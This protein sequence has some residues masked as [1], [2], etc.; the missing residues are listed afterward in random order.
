MSRRRCAPTRRPARTRVAP[1]CCSRLTSSTWLCG[2]SLAT[3]GGGAAASVGAA[4]CGLGCGERQQADAERGH[5]AHGRARLRPCRRIRRLRPPALMRVEVGRR[6]D[7]LPGKAQADH[8][9][10]RR[11]QEAQLLGLQPLA[12]DRAELRADH[13]A[14][15]SAARPATTSTVWFCEACSTVVAAVRNTIWNSEVPDHDVGRHAQEIDHRRHHDEAAAHAHDGGQQADE[16]A[17][18]EAAGWR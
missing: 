7:Q 11:Q 10:Q 2:A 9:H 3:G 17:D 5:Q 13:A 8:Q 16:Q 6:R 4:A 18:A 1:G 15:P 14:R 12:C